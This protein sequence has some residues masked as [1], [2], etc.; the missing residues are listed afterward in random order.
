MLYL[1]LGTENAP[2]P[3]F[4]PKAS[5]YGVEVGCSIWDIGL[6]FEERELQNDL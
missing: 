6:V 2:N 1:P 5:Q 3:D 4:A